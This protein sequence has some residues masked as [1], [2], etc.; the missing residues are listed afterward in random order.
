MF[1]KDSS[2]VPSEFITF[3]ELDQGKFPDVNGNFRCPL[4]SRIINEP[5]YKEGWGEDTC[6]TNIGLCTNNDVG[7]DV[8]CPEGQVIKMTYYEGNT[9]LS[10]HVGTT[11]EECCAPPEVPTITVPLDAD[12][13]ELMADETTF[14]E[15]FISDIVGILNSSD[16]ITFLITPEMIEF[17]AIDPGSIIV[18][19]KVRKSKSGE[20]VLKEQIAKTLT[21]G[22]TFQRVG[23]VTKGEVNFKEYN[24]GAKFDYYSKAFGI[25]IS[26]EELVV[27]III[28]FSLCFF[29]LVVMG[30][31]MK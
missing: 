30:M 17:V 6:C 26:N 23:A 2:S 3:N 14:K 21:I 9:I 11:P 27:S 29:C 10:P 24:P 31:L 19:F 8:I 16:D 15:N 7:I 28:T 25:G 1:S 5:E 4:P 18:T 20:V 13:D 12:Y 22:K